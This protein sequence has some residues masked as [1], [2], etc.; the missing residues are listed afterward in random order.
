MAQDTSQNTPPPSDC[1]KDPAG[2]PPDVTLPADDSCK[3]LD[4]G[5]TPP[6]LCTLPTCT[7]SCTCPSVPSDKPACLDTLIKNEA[8]AINKGDQAKKFKAD[9]EALLGKVKAATLEYTA[10]SYKDLVDRWKTEDESIVC[11]IRS[12]HCALPCWWCVIECEI[13]PLVNDIHGQELK[14]S[15]DYLLAGETA[16]APET[17]PPCVKSIYDLRFWWWREKLRR[18][19]LFDHVANVMKAWETPFKTIDGI[20]KANAE[21]IKTISA[22]LNVDQKKEA[23][24]YLFD[25]V[26]LVRQHL[27]IAPPVSEATTGIEKR[28]VE[29]CCCDQSGELHKCCGVVIRLPTVLDRVI[30]ALPYL[31]RPEKYPDLI[32]CLA[33]KVYQP[34]R[35]SAVEADSRLSELETEVKNTEAAIVAQLKSLP[36]DAKVRLGKTIEC[37]D[38][39]PRTGSDGAKAKCCDDDD[40]P[41]PCAEKPTSGS[42]P[43]QTTPPQYPN[44]AQSA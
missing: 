12:I 24:K 33:T 22:A 7:P 32:C 26:R 17:D 36:A 18:Q 30:G 14:L 6:R 27:A 21:I 43:S 25:L 16:P 29:I 4:I 9:L 31:V 40:P 3:P 37:K 38:Y 39:K 1:K 34:T 28:Y 5:R 42:D 2:Q 19:A 35:K 20:L 13:C 44:P 23:S 15:G 10:D 41:P 8:D 11:L